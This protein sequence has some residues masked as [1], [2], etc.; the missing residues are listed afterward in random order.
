MRGILQ[1]GVYD[2]CVTAEET[3]KPRNNLEW[4]FYLWAVV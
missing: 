4:E 3:Q 2:N 1:P